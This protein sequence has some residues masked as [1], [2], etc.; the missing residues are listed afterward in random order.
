MQAL[1]SLLFFGPFVFFQITATVA[2]AVA[3]ATAAAGTSAAAG[4]PCASALPS[5]AYH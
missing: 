2:A 3:G 5:A 4:A 1:F